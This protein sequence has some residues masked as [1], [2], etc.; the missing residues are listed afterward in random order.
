MTSRKD[1]WTILGIPR[2]A[3]IDEIK[4]QY[5]KLA[6]KL[7]PDKHTADLT[8]EQR[9]EREE[10]FKEV[11][12]A[13][14]VATDIAKARENGC[15]FASSD[16]YEKW[17]GMWERVEAMINNKTLMET[18]SKALKNTL[19]DLAINTI[20]RMADPSHSAHS[21]NSTHSTHESGDDASDISSNV[22]TSSYTSVDS[23]LD[24]LHRD[25]EPRVFKLQVS[26]DDIH[27]KQSKRVRLFLSDH[28]KDPFFINISY[29]NFPEIT[30]T[31][32][33]DHT[34]YTIVIR[35]EA[36]QHPIYYW[37]PLLSGWD[38][39]TTVPISLSEYMI[40]CIRTIPWL[41]DINES[42]PIHLA[43]PA[44]PNIKKPIVFE[45]L[46]LRQKGDLYV[47]LEVQLPTKKN[48][49]I[50]EKEDP[51]MLKEFLCVCKKLENPNA[52]H[53]TQS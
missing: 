23:N 20:S 47:M 34:E 19:K 7:H 22:D 5:K 9:K 21:T 6:L 33:H 32:I 45:K 46:G 27:T 52:P 4:S 40:G 17:K 29:D 43:V 11:T 50:L 41:G 35:M 15:D 51:N 14:Q 26:L 48:L 8:P 39:Y 49:K 36:K 10:H 18:F 1:P 24:V 2:T 37:D 31:H 13:Y 28:P 25:L 38:L 12:V 3:S 42:N 30:S 44:F 16:D 53:H